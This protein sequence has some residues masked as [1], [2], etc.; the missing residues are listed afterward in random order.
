M[1]VTIRAATIGDVRVILELIG[2]LAEYERL[3]HLVV[4]D[5]TRLREALFG[6]RPGAE[7][8]L[9]E[10]NQQVVGFAVYFQSFSTFWG[11]PGIY[12]EDLFVKPDFRGRGIGRTLLEQ[13]ARETLQRGGAR[14]EWSV[15]N[16]NEPAIR[17]YQSLGATPQ[18]EWTVYRLT[19]AALT[20]LA[21][22]SSQQK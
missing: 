7:V 1:S 4:A 5:E 17:F 22:S 6:P 20:N 19:G 9:A 2:E 8:L 14:L 3:A 16:W 10:W 21:E 18:D 13:L 11:R 12:L 15:L